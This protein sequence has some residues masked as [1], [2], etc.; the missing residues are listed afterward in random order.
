MW[1]VKTKKKGDYLFV[2]LKYFNITNNIFNM[3]NEYSLKKS[4]KHPL[5]SKLINRLRVFS[6]SDC[7]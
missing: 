6:F 1:N 3:K 7:I 2:I 4:K 5:K